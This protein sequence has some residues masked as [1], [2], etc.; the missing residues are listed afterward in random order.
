MNSQTGSVDSLK[1]EI[2]DLKKTVQFLQWRVDFLLSYLGI[3][4]ASDAKHGAQ[5]DNNG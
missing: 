3:I 1:Q 5:L 4:T 2:T